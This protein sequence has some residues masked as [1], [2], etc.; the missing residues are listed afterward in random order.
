MSC[1][2]WKYLCDNPLQH[3]EVGTASQ[4]N[5]CG[6]ALLRC[7]FYRSHFLFWHMKQPLTESQDDLHSYWATAL[8]QGTWRFSAA[9]LAWLL[10][11]C[12]P[13]I[14][15]FI[16][17]ALCVN[18]RLKWSGSEMNMKHPGEVL[19][20]LWC[21]K[22]EF[23]QKWACGSFHGPVPW[24]SLAP[25]LNCSPVQTC[26]LL[27]NLFPCLL[28][29]PEMEISFLVATARVCSEGHHQLCTLQ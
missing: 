19:C 25:T 22:N 27:N 3:L 23:V 4:E 14:S 13:F 6:K 28:Q 17:D 10:G 24:D 2:G 20:S 29:G 12:F 1:L 11:F 18:M 8:W 9:Q 26:L 15:Q 21:L 7:L 16:S 5:A